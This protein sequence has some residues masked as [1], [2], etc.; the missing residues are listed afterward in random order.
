MTTPLVVTAQEI[1]TERG[2]KTDGRLPTGGRQDEVGGG[3]IPTRIHEP[4]LGA[5]VPLPLRSAEDGVPLRSAED[6]AA[7]GVRRSLAAP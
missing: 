6:G 1:V 3:T 5:R 4:A 2:M 7:A